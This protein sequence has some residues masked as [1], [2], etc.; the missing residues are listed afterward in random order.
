VDRQCVPAPMFRPSP[1]ATP[2]NAE[3]TLLTCDSK[4]GTT[5]VCVRPK[6]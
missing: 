1:L 5:D 4:T 6:A 3:R 2:G